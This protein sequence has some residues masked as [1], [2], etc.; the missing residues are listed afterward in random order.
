MTD[1]VW[2][3]GYG[4]LVSPASLS[5]TIGRFIDDVH[6]RRV[7]HL[8]GFGR[9]WNYGSP[10]QRGH[11]RLGDAHVRSGVIICLGVVFSAAE[12][13]NG[14]VV[15]VNDDELAELDWRERD[16]DRVDVNDH[17]RVETGPIEGPVV[18]YVPRPSAIERYREARDQGRAAVSQRYWDLVHGAFADLGG[19]HLEHLATRTPLPDVPVA[20]VEP[21]D[22]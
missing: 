19:E 8:D 6:S 4:S 21:A 1:S 18:T 16:Y 17:V 20:E 9:K 13:C 15:R 7:A 11:W 12:S 22:D 3:F 2:V 14:V 5:R 10:T